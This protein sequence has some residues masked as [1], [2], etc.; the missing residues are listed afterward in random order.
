[1]LFIK[2]HSSIAALSTIYLVICSSK[3]LSVSCICADTVHQYLFSDRNGK[4]YSCVAVIC[5]NC[6]YIQW[7]VIL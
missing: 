4:V 2:R 3:V 5:N 1:M 6:N 7:S